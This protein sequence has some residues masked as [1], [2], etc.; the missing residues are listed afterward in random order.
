M[1]RE[2]HDEVSVIM[3][4]EEWYLVQEALL[5]FKKDT[6]NL[7]S[8]SIYIGRAKIQTVLLTDRAYQKIQDELYRD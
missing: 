7:E 2:L 8:L 3:N 4:R 6:N 5:K 1:G